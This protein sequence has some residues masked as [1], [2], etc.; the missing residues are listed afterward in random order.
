MNFLNKKLF[1]AGHPEST[2][3]SHIYTYLYVF[4]SIF[5]CIDIQESKCH[6]YSNEL[7]GT[8]SF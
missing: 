8:V 5:A 7:F 1:D 6:V 2:E 4:W 3:V